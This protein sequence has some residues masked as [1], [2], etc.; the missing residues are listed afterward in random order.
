MDGPLLLVGDLASGLE[1]Q[2]GMAK[3]SNQPGLGILPTFE[4]TIA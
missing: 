3:L 4:M 1:L 2:N